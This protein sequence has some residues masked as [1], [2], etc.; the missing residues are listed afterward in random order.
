MDLVVSGAFGYGELET[1][2]V[3]LGLDVGWSLLW[4][5][6][7]R[8]ETY[9]NVETVALDLVGAGEGVSGITRVRGD[10]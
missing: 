1:M 5:M 9:R 8:R 10:D 3:L 2:L 6:A 4:L 7:W